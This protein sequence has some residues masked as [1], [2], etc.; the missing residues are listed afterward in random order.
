MVLT[1]KEALQ[2]SINCLNIKEYAEEVVAAA[3]NMKPLQLYLNFERKFSS[4][5]LQRF[6][7]ILQRRCCGEPLLYITQ[8]VEFYG[9]RLKL[10]PAVLIPRLETELLVDLIVCELKESQNQPRAVWDL[11]TGSG[12]IGIAIK[13]K[14]PHLQV[15]LSDKSVEA[16]KIAEKNAEDNLVKIAI[17]QGD[18]LAPYAGLEADLIVCNPPYISEAEYLELDREV[19]DFEPKSALVADEDGLQFYKRLAEEAPSYL[20]VGGRI[21]L[22]IG[23]KQGGAILEF[24][25]KSGWSDGVI[26]KDLAG[27]DRF[28]S[29][30]K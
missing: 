9:C 10:T 28:F 3:L 11:C 20:K 26:L 1:V 24:F 5:E 23:W 21:W 19:R 30:T 29:A 7:E 4:D 25:R 22:E 18:L 17:L 12:C 16:L 8:E 15:T 27:H 13:K 2:L 6:E 14:L